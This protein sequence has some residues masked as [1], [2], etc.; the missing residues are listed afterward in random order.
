VSWL[1]D[2]TAL[3]EPDDMHR[4]WAGPRRWLL[5]VAAAGLLAGCQAGRDASP[6]TSTSTATAAGR[7]EPAPIRFSG[8]KAART[9]PFLLAGGLTVFGGEHRGGGSFRVEI[10][11][12]KGEPQRVLFLATGRY[13]GSIGLGLQGGIYRLSVAAGTPWTVEITQPRGQAGV[14]LPQRYQGASD[15][16]VGPFRVDRDVQVEVEHDGEGDLSVELLS[17]QGP[18]LYFLVEDSGRFRASRTAAGLEPG[19]YYL[20]VEARK[21]WRLALRAG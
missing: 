15:A 4:R 2:D 11:N 5:L 8:Q 1:A 9:E 13:R 18:S 20:N 12:E 21:P 16:L 10:L 17:D 3:E 19:A 6:P 14:A 7:H